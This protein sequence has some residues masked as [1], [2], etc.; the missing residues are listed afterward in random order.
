[1]ARPKKLVESDYDLVVR[2]AGQGMSIRACSEILGIDDA[3]A[4]RDEKFC[5]IY[6]KAYHQFGEKVRS[7]LFEKAINGDT[8]ACIYLD[9]VINKTT[10]K[11]HD[12]NIKMKREQLELEKQKAKDLADKPFVFELKGV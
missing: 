12:D 3:T 4:Y 5:D 11:A 1:M 9:K 8:T 10:E 2:L 6:K 7:Q